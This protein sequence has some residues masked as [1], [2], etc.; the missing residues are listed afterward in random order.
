MAKRFYYMVQGGYEFFDGQCFGQAW[1]DAKAKA[2]ELHVAVFRRVEQDGKDDRFEV[3]LKGGCFL[4]V[5]MV[6]EDRYHIF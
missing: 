2:S 1:K 6:G 3:Y 4:P 5:G